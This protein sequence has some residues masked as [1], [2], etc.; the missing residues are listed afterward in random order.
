LEIELVE[1]AAVEKDSVPVCPN[2]SESSLTHRL[3]DRAFHVHLTWDYWNLRIC[4]MSSSGHEKYQQA[5]QSLGEGFNH[6]RIKPYLAIQPRSRPRLLSSFDDKL[7][8]IPPPSGW[9]SSQP[10]W[11]FRSV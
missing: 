5:A 1:A 7:G 2:E 3:L 4:R 9:I 11:K 8:V 10:E 6:Q